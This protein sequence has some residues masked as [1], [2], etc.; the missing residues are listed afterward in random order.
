MTPLNLVNLFLAIAVVADEKQGQRDQPVDAAECL[1]KEG[2]PRPGDEDK[3][4]WKGLD[5]WT[6]L[7]KPNKPWQCNLLLL[8]QPAA[9]AT[10]Y[11]CN[12]LLVQSSAM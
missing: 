12:L 2:T 3:G 10:C 6:F 11:W 7:D 1:M 9:G 4:G 5:G 8:V